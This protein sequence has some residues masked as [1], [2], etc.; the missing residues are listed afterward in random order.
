MTPSEYIYGIRVDFIQYNVTFAL[1]KSIVF[2]FLIASVSSFTGY[3]TAGGALEVGKASTKAV[4]SS[5]IAILSAD[6][7]LAQLLL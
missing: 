1:I 4:T 5:C 6:Y 7:L 2:A 3:F